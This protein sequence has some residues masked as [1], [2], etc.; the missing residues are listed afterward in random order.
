MDSSEGAQRRGRR[1][2]FRVPARSTSRDR[3]FRR[4]VKLVKSCTGRPPSTKV[5]RES[6][7]SNTQAVALGRHQVLAQGSPS[8]PTVKETCSFAALHSYD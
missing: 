7:G 5:M 3:R 2:P 8:R 1:S 6:T 4:V